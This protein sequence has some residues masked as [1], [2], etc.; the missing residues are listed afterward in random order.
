[1]YDVPVLICGLCHSYAALKFEIDIVSV[2]AAML[3]SAVN[4]S[5]EGPP[6]DH[7][8]GCR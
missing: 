4:A 3:T 7:S 8:V 5:P 2:G 6:P 1:M